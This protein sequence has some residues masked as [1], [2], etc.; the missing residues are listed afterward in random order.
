MATERLLM[1][2]AHEILRTK[3]ELRF[4]NREAARSARVSPATVVNVV[5]RA[6]EAG[7]TTYAD[8]EALSELELEASLYPETDSNGVPRLRPEHDCA[9]I[10]RERSRPG[11]TLELLHLEYLEQHPGGL[12]YTAFCDRYRTFQKRRGLA[13]RQTHIAG[14]KLFVDYSGKR[15]S[16]V[17]PSTGE[18]TDVELFVAVLGASNYT[19][20]E[21]TYSQQVHDFVGS[22]LRAFAYFGGAP[23]AIVPDNLRSGVTRACFYEPTIQR[24]YEHMALHY[25]TGVDPVSW[26]V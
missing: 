7:Y 6:I 17:E 18:V 20:A 3:W 22:H 1:R 11:V 8:V 2:K 24:S 23:R 21:A 10:H 5:R 4:S 26:T 14:D 9:W 25:G 12:Q 16:L 19:Y 15:P 13:M